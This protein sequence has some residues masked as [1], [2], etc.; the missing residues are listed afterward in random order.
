MEGEGGREKMQK[1][2]ANLDWNLYPGDLGA[3][4]ELCL[5]S[6]QGSA[7]I[8]LIILGD[9]PKTCQ[10]RQTVIKGLSKISEIKWIMKAQVT[11]VT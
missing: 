6:S 5:L 2:F 1:K 8:P 11:V 10:T 9:Y 3:R 4:P 7:F